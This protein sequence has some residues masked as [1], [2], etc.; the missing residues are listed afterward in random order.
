M[1]KRGM[2]YFFVD[3]LEPEDAI[4]SITGPDARHI[5]TVLRLKPGDKI[6]LFDGKGFDCEAQIVD[7]SPGKVTASLIRRFP[8]TAES[9]I[10]IT[11]AQGFL[12]E[13]KMDGLVRQL[14]ELGITKW[15][16]FIAERSVSIPDKKQLASRAKRWEKIAKEA[17]KQCR[18]G[19][20]MK[21]GD[22]ASFSQVLNLAGD[23]DLK[24]AFW[25]NES[26]P[27]QPINPQSPVQTVFALIGPE[28]GFTRREIE[29]AKDYGFIA[30]SLGPRILRAETAAVAASVLLQYLFGDMN[31]KYL[32]KKTG[33]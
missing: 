24:I 10:Q 3:S 7:F 16:P 22:T 20:I 21:I 4:F 9:P 19:R 17:V 31:Q 33:L 18:R 25:E 32:D 27:V 2:R 15:M 23:C 29:V 30:A 8:S 14:S 12:K 26:R 6:G 28:G 1:D 13:R 11:I 5:R